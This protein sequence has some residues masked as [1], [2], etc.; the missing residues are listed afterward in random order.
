MPLNSSEPNPKGK[1]RVVK[2]EK[3]DKQDR[4]LQAGNS[5]SMYVDSAATHKRKLLLPNKKNWH[6]SSEST[7]W[8][9]RKRDKETKRPI[10]H[11]GETSIIMLNLL[12]KKIDVYVDS[13][14]I[15]QAKKLK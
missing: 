11:F 10:L 6:P 4:N 14:M 2:F 8:V 13:V 12:K 9:E 5:K 1:L 7:Y 3:C 15:I